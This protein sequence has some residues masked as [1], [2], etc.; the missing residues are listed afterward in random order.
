ME[1]VNRIDSSAPTYMVPKTV[2][3]LRKSNPLVAIIMAVVIITI[4]FLLV[5]AGYYFITDCYSKK[6]LMSYL[7]SMSFDPCYLKTGT[8]KTSLPLVAR[9]VADDNEVFN[10]Q[11]QDYT[12]DQAKCKCRAYNGR[13]ATK[14]EI[15]DAYNKGANWCSYGWSEGQSAYYPTQKCAWD[16]LQR[17]PRKDRHNC[18]RPGVNGGFFANP[19]LKFGANCYGIKP[20]GKV[21]KE[22]RPICKSKPFCKL[23]TNRRAGEKL[24]TDNIQPFN[25]DKWSRY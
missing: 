17:G 12:Y 6:P 2:Q 1:A 4:L 8:K 22:K 18:G 9:E 3:K 13:L 25:N 24:D 23:R 20:A 14:A 21:E 5:N 15:I 11:N 7:Q 19:L 10:I 16:K